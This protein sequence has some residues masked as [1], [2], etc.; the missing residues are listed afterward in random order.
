MDNTTL[1]LDTVYNG[2]DAVARMT[3]LIGLEGPFHFFAE[4]TNEGRG[5]SVYFQD[6]MK[7]LHGA[8]HLKGLPHRVVERTLEKAL[9]SFTNTV[10]L[11][12]GISDKDSR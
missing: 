11:L 8:P 4:P 7:P 6:E 3:L 5:V 12:D 2:P 1:N 9:A 10:R